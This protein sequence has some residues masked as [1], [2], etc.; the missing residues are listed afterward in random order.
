MTRCFG[1]ILASTFFSFCSST[2]HPTAS[3]TI[4]CA[5]SVHV[6]APKSIFANEE[7][8]ANGLKENVSGK[9]SMI[10]QDMTQADSADESAACDTPS[11]NRNPLNWWHDPLQSL[12]VSTCVMASMTLGG[13]LRHPAIG[14]VGFWTVATYASFAV[15]LLVG[16][17]LVHRIY[18]DHVT[19]APQGV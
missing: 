5:L 9:V 8:P 15:G 12:F 19:G 2:S 1:L 4:T 17:I 7:N 11:T 6:P 14:S 10:Q 16:Q 13:A 3:R 18:R